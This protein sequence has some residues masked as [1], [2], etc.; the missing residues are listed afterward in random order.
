MKKLKKRQQQEIVV[1]GFTINTSD[2]SE[3]L[4]AEAEAEAAE[5]K[6]SL[7]EAYSLF[8]HSREQEQAD[9]MSLVEE[10]SVRKVG[11]GGAL[12]TSIFQV[13]FKFVHSNQMD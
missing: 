8:P 13:L 7:T 6:R 2:C 4:E 12:S 11:G 9:E 1:S 5:D 3:E 10:T